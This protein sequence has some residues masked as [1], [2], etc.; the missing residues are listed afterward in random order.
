MNLK[1]LQSFVEFPFIL[2]SNFMRA[3]N[4]LALKFKVFIV[5]PGEATTLAPT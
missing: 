5:L 4:L 3:E 2:P 1:K